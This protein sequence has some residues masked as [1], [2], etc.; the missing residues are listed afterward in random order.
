MAVRH[1][2]HI[3]RL[4]G[5]C[6]GSRRHVTSD[7]LCLK[8]TCQLADG[9]LGADCEDEQH[10]QKRKSGFESR[11]HHFHFIRCPVARF[12]GTMCEAS[13]LRKQAQFTWIFQC[14]SSRLQILCLLHKE[15]DSLR[16][17]RRRQTFAANV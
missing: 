15:G 14:S 2:R 17:R 11:R 9:C 3:Q 5:F 7:A 6:G 1:N 8:T 10:Q 4:S 16:R 13:A 12:W